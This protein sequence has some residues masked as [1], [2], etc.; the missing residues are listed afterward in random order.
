MSTSTYY[1]LGIG[2]VG[3]SAL[4]RHFWKAQ[5][6]VF[7]YDKT[8]TPLTQELEAMGIS[9]TYDQEVAA[10]PQACQAPDTKIVYTAALPKNHPQ[11]VYFQE[12]KF[13]IEKRA[14]VLG[15]LSKLTPCIA[16]AGTHG[17]TTTTALLSHLLY[18]TK[19][20]FTAFVGGIMNQFNSNYI[21][22]GSDFLLVEADEYDRSFLQLSP[23]YIGITSMDAD[24]LDIYETADQL[25]ETYK[26]F[27]TRCSHLVHAE[28][29]PLEGISY[30]FGPNAHYRA[31]DLKPIETGY[32]FTFVTPQA[33]FPN[34]VLNMLGKH[35]LMNALAA[36]TLGHQIGLQ[37]DEMTTALPSFK[38]I[39]RRMNRYDWKDKVL[40]DD[41]AHHPKEIE[42]VYQSLRNHYST[43]KIAVVFQPHLFSRTQDFWEAFCTILSKFDAVALMDI[44]PA[45]E[46]P[47]EGITAA[48]LLDAISHPQKT[49][50]QPDELNTYVSHSP[51]EIVA[52][53]GAGD[54]GLAIQNLIRVS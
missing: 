30:G 9:I 10:I 46:L 47:I 51:C 27:S 4:A 16:V 44:Y 42:A 15:A 24:H 12:R 22:T 20:S 23:D 32:A 19:Q 35:N 34:V 14:A 45:R 3:M 33:S 36:L 53:L 40:I 41:Y 31:S 38:G 39:Q 43:H 13:S 50:V 21:H 5:H 25:E 29:L 11:L 52:L 49:M 18:H 1:F 7:G 26:M 37:L 54:I 48:R 6:R 2:G 28:G 8:P 17:K